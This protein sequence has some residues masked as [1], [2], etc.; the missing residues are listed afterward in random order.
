MDGDDPFDRRTLERAREQIDD[1]E[2][3]DRAHDEL[4]ESRQRLLVIERMRQCGARFDERPEPPFGMRALASIR[5]DGRDRDGRV[6]GRVAKIEEVVPNRDRR[7]RPEIAQSKVAGPAPV[8]HQGR[9]NDFAHVR[10]IFG[11]EVIVGFAASRVLERTDL[12]QRAPGCVDERYFARKRRDS[13]KVVT[14]F[15]ERRERAA[16]FLDTM[17]T[18]DVGE[19]RE[20]PDDCA[21]LGIEGR[22]DAQPRPTVCAVGDPHGCFIVEGFRAGGRGEP[23]RAKRVPLPGFD[24]LEPRISAVRAHGSA[25]QLVPTAGNVRHESGAMREKSDDSKRV[26]RVEKT[27]VLPRIFRIRSVFHRIGALLNRQVRSPLTTV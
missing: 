15:G 11:Q 1:A 5:A 25:G 27:G 18:I 10:E 7:M 8:T 16:L 3:R 23:P 22:R 20:P 17:L 4:R 6:R 26:E 14:V 2:R 13:D 12:Q 9:V 21:R 19:R 24:A